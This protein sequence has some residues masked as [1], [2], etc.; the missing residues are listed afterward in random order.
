VAHAWGLLA[1]ALALGLTREKITRAALRGDIR[2]RLVHHDGTAA[3]LP[4]DSW[5]GDI[6]WSTSRIVPLQTWNISPGGFRWHRPPSGTVEVDLDSVRDHFGLTPAPRGG[7]PRKYEWERA[8]IEV[9]ARPYHG[10]T[11]EPRS[12][13][14]VERLLAQWFVEHCGEQP[15]E[16]EIRK[17]AKKLFEAIQEE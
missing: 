11:P 7:R 2:A 9:F 14:E 10:K 12:Q 1:D 16:S 3:E 5:R 4:P 8:V 15:A 17:R 6:E 13:A